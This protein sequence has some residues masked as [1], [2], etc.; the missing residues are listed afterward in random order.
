MIPKH[1]S[2]LPRSCWV[3]ILAVRPKPKGDTHIIVSFSSWYPALSPSFMTGMAEEER[4]KCGVYSATDN[5][6]C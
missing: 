6:V 2:A 3:L 5:W 4:K 1:D